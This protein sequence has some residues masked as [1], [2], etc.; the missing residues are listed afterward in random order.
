MNKNQFPQLRF[1]LVNFL[2][3]LLCAVYVNGSANEIEYKKQG[4]RIDWEAGENLNTFNRRPHTLVLTAYQLSDPNV[5]NQL[6]ED[7]EGISKLLEGDSFDSSV[8]SRRKVVVKPNEQQKLYLDRAAGAQYIGLVTGYFTQ[9][10]R[11]MSRLVPVTL[12]ER[13]RF[14][15][16]KKDKDPADTIVQLTL[17]SSKINELKIVGVDEIEDGR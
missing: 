15:W 7:P 10:V 5:F 16:R 17:G 2:G 12:R 13:N 14:F 11:A 9:D 3:L 6:L 4:V 1:I 8:L